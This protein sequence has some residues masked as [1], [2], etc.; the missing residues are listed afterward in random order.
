MHAE[1][2]DVDDAL[3]R[4]LLAMQVP[5]YA[6]LPLTRIEAWGTDHAIFRLGDDLS[7]RLPKIGWAAKQGEKEARWLPR[8]APHLLP[9]QVPMPIVVG[10]PGGGYPFRWYVSPWLDGE[11][12]RPDGEGPADLGHLAV[13]LAAFVRA[14][15]RIDTTGGPAPGPGRRG[16]P[17]ADADTSTRERAEQVRGETDVDALLDVWASGVRAPQW[18]RPAVWCHGD[19]ADGNLL[20]RRG[21]LSG[22]I[23]WGSLVV[24]DPAVDLMV[25]WQLFDAESR[26]VYRDALDFVDDATWLRAKAWA[27]STALH[28]LPYYRDTNPDI[29][30]RSWRVVRE[31]LAEQP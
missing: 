24:G 10:Q 4:R 17:L 29:M 5:Q 12:P 28:A 19:L 31:V 6:S 11:N 26:A 23:D 21:R 1:E 27:V 14:L 20:V 3:V 8:F 9:V 25:A 22:V 13:E 16:G 2:V 15:Q 7:V 18:D 30:A